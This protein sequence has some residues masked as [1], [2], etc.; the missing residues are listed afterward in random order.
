MRVPFRVQA[1]Q[2]PQVTNLMSA[3][4]KLKSAR[5]VAEDVTEA[6]VGEKKFGSEIGSCSRGLFGL[7]G[8]FG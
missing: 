8:G 1:N 5:E 3:A 4:A 6:I 2:V 7:L